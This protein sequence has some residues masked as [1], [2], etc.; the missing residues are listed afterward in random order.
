MLLAPYAFEHKTCIMD[1]AVQASDEVFLLVIFQ[2][3]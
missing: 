3:A 1:A 2:F